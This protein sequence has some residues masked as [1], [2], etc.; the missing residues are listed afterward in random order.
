MNPAEVKVRALAKVDE[1]APQLID[2]SHEIHAHPEL[3]FEERFAHDLLTDLIEEHGVAVTRHAY[4]LETAFEARAGHE[5]PVVAIC[6]EYDALPSVGHACGHNVIATAGVGAGLAA[7]AVAEGAG[8]RV[9][10]LGTPAEEGGGGKVLMADRGAFADVDVA[11]MVHPAWADLPAMEVIAI[12]QLW[13]TYHGEA[14]HAAAAPHR[15]RN[16]LDAMVLGYMNVAALRQHILPTE[17][18]HGIF[19]EAGDQA[20]IV[21]E[22]TRA[23]WYVRSPDRAGLEALKERVLRCLIAGA[24]AAGC[25][26]EY[27]WKEPMYADLV[28]NGPLLELYRQ[29]SAALGR[30]LLDTSDAAR[31]V[32]STD[33][34]N[35][36]HLVPSIHPMIQVSPPDVPIHC[37]EF[38]EWAAAGDGDRAVVD[39]A[40]AMASTAVDVWTRPD[41]LAEIRAAFGRGS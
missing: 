20:N 35:V 40:K 15:G 14:A 36:S 37:R 7:A 32:G 34:G 12:Q 19:T 28:S 18:I 6:C 17:R 8:G 1:L 41:A 31:V 21:P 22:C 4:E 9:V 38:A 26:I 3:C 5:G 13:V 16:A 2:A 27:T 23:R 33:M 11:M 24:E 29:N 25:E 10:I 39:G 30:P